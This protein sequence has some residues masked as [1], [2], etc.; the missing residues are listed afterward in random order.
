M[1][2]TDKNQ[3]K[4]DIF[5]FYEKQSAEK[6]K[7]FLSWLESGS[8]RIPQSKSYYYFE[9]RKINKALAMANIKEKASI[10]EIG[11]NLGQMTFPLAEM[12]YNMTGFDLSKNAIDLANKRVQHYGVKNIRFEVH[13]AESYPDKKD[14]SFDAVFSFSA[15]RYFPNPQNAFNEAYRVIRKGGTMIVDFPNK[16]CPWF[17]LLK[18]S[19]FIK[20]HIHDN[21][22]TKDQIQT[23]MSDAGFV[24][25]SFSI[26]LFTYKELPPFLLPFMKIIDFIG[27]CLPGIRQLA[28]IL[29]VKGEKL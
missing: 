26:F 25:I 27:E 3:I 16:Y 4:D 8:P 29:M 19:L 6:T 15:F 7:S 17:H 20:S 10:L 2:K 1:D 12:G 23:M 28:A 21:I 18:P 13:D 22:Y 11:C 24:N 5:D 14:E 9:D